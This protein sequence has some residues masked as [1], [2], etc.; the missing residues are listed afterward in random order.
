M[1]INETEARTETMR[2]RG[3]RGFPKPPA[4][5]ELMRV[6][7]EN[8]R[9]IRHLHETITRIIDDE[10]NED[11]PRPARLRSLLRPSTADAGGIPP[12]RVCRLATCPGDGW[13]VHYF[14]RT[15]GKFGT[16]SQELTQEQ[17]ETLVCEENQRI[18]EGVARC[19]CGAVT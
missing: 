14:L 18:Y 19:E 17:A 6:S 5:L 12:H 2:L 3:L 1:L 11:C 10:S 16:L 13:R 4:D 15:K 9:D 8:A 7:M